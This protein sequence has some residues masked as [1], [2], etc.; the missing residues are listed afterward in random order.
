LTPLNYPQS[1][2]VPY[3]WIYII[4]LQPSD[5]K[6]VENRK[7]TGCALSSANSCKYQR[8]KELRERKWERP[9]QQ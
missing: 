2:T 3:L 8:E 5:G 7:K 1:S 4:A 6:F 9:S